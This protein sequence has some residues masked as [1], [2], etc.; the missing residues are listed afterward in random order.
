MAGDNG[1]HISWEESI[2]VYMNLKWCHSLQYVPATMCIYRLVAGAES[3]SCIDNVLT[4]NS[5]TN[6]VLDLDIQ[7]Q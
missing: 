6:L 1:M 4:D 3:I 5:F 7:Y 2:Q